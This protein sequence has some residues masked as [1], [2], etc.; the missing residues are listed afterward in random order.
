MEILPCTRED[1]VDILD[2]LTAFWGSGRTAASHHPILIEE[3]GDTAFVVRDGNCICAYLF[4][5]FAQTGPYFY[6]HLVGIRDGYK[7]QGIGQRLY[8]HVED[9]ARVRG[10]TALKAITSVTNTGSLSFHRAL[11][12]EQTGEAEQAGLRYTPAY[13]GRGRDMVVMRKVL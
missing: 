10:V 11:G 6:I 4:G 13:A 12:F 2:D 9:L 8:A 7:R 5:F 1:F 3:F